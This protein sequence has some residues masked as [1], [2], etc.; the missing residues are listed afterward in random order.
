MD[1]DYA[2]K[3]EGIKALTRPDQDFVLADIED[4]ACS[5]P[6]DLSFQIVAEGKRKRIMVQTSPEEEPFDAFPLSNEEDDDSDS[7]EEEDDEEDED[8]DEEELETF[9]GFEIRDSIDGVPFMIR[10]AHIPDPDKGTFKLRFEKF[11]L[12]VPWD[13]IENLLED[14]NMTNLARMNWIRNVSED[15]YRMMLK[16]RLTIDYQLIEA[17]WKK[18]KV[19]SKKKSSSPKK[20]SKSPSKDKK[21]STP[22]KK[23]LRQRVKS[24]F[25]K[26]KKKVTRTAVK[27][28]DKVKAKAS[29]AKAAVKTKV[30]SAKKAVAKKIPKR[31]VKAL[32]KGARK[33][34]QAIRKGKTGSGAAGDQKKPRPPRGAKDQKRL[35]SATAKLASGQKLTSK[36]KRAVKRAVKEAYKQQ[37]KQ[38]TGTT[39]KGKPVAGGQRLS[40]TRGLPNVGGG[41]GG[42]VGGGGAPGSGAS[43]G[44]GS[45]GGGG[46]PPLGAGDASGNAPLPSSSAAASAASSGT[47]GSFVRVAPTASTTKPTTT[48]PVPASDTSTTASNTSSTSATS[49]RSSSPSRWSRLRD[50]LP[51]L[52]GPSSTGGT[53][54]VDV[55]GGS[56]GGDSGSSAFAGTAAD[57]SPPADQSNTVGDNRTLNAAALGFGGGAVLGATAGSLSRPAVYAPPPVA[58]TASAATFPPPPQTRL[59]PVVAP[60]F[61]GNNLPLPTATEDTALPTT[62]PTNLDQGLGGNSPGLPPLSTSGSVDAVTGEPLPPPPQVPGQASSTSTSTA[63][64]S[65][66]TETG[67]SSSSKPSKPV[68]QTYKFKPNIV[69]GT[70]EDEVS[71][72]DSDSDTSQAKSIQASIT[73]EDLVSRKARIVNG[74]ERIYREKFG[75][76]PTKVQLDA[77]RGRLDKVLVLT[78]AKAVEVV[79]EWIIEVMGA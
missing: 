33:K 73:V 56:G 66:A 52:S 11:K 36:E 21:K 28:R 45:S 61:G 54:G 71:G 69:A 68:L 43:G 65:E 26:A 2:E 16:E 8:E 31:V 51:S 22:K 19:P 79:V 27:A 4:D 38:A 13:Q 5:I 62:G 17:T 74:V 10:F 53:G 15:C 14:E 37:N 35:Q 12:Y 18:G 48:V 67:T 40:P 49:S 75:V 77:L 39:T 20:K 78:A 60:P 7:E 50:K 32:P 30:A 59:G 76:Q 41:P 47:T 58:P 70:D 6:V 23:T 9:S 29:Q 34:I 55:G 3:E 1:E 63:G 72:S 46:T 44:G 24:N 64:A 42:G 57:F 25:K